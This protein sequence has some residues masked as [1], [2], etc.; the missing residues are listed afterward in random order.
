[1]VEKTTHMIQEVQLVSQQI[2]TAEHCTC[3]AIK[4]HIKPAGR[5]SWS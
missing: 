4:F 2:T 3:L 1:L 5:S